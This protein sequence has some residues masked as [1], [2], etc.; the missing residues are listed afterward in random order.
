[1]ILTER[2]DH[3]L[4]GALLQEEAT[5]RVEEEVAVER[6]K[7]L[8][9]GRKC[10]RVPSPKRRAERGVRGVQLEQP[11]DVLLRRVREVVA[12]QIR[13]HLALCAVRERSAGVLSSG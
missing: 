13:C 6:C 12:G 10:K 9:L 2:P 1:M 4:P 3:P 5:R 11:R 8:V 7:A